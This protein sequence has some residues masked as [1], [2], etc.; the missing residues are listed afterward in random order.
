M[1]MDPKERANKKNP[2]NKDETKK[3][4]NPD[5]EVVASDDEEGE[6]DEEN[7]SAKGNKKKRIKKKDKEEIKPNC[8]YNLYLQDDTNADSALFQWY[9]FSC[10]NVRADT[11]IRIN[12]CNLSKPNGLYNKG[13]KPF[14]YSINKHKEKG[15]GW[16]RGCENVKYF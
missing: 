3:D 13:M 7:K 6:E 11:L 12:I 1:K 16:H 2:L 10:M 4:E 5:L 15:I 8:E 9:Y 14:L